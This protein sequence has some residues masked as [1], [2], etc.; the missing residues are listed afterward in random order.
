MAPGKRPLLSGENGT[1]Q[2]AVRLLWDRA[3]ADLEAHAPGRTDAEMLDFL[4]RHRRILRCVKHIWETNGHDK[5]N[6]YLALGYASG[7]LYMMGSAGTVPAAYRSAA[8][9]SEELLDWSFWDKACDFWVRL[10]AGGEEAA[11]VRGAL[12][13]VICRDEDGIATLTERF[14]LIA[15]AWKC[16]AAGE[17]ITAEG[18]RLSYQTDEYGAPRLSET[19]TVGG[20]DLGEP[21]EDES[22]GDEQDD[23]PPEE[24][25]MRRGG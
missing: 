11:A 17:P 14:A 15:K 4:A 10:A 23:S 1:A 24:S 2:F 19:P 9:P 13:E 3:C 21:A 25:V 18:L 6:P 16:V 22:V 5:L 20:I 7:F 8:H 12:D